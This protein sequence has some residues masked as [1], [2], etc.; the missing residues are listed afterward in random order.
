MVV[1]ARIVADLRF[2][3]AKEILDL[4]DAHLLRLSGAVRELF[5]IRD[6]LTDQLLPGE[7]VARK[8]VARSAALCGRDGHATP[9]T[10]GL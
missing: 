8:V 1:P 6:V 5:R 10:A 9:G 3:R 4:L 7:V 2:M